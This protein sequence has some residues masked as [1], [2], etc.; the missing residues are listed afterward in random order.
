[1]CRD[2]KQWEGYVFQLNGESLIRK[3]VRTCSEINSMAVRLATGSAWA[4]Y[5]MASTSRRCPSTYRGSE[6]RSRRLRPMLG[7]TGIVK[8]LA[9]RTRILLRQSVL[10]VALRQ[11]RYTVQRPACSFSAF[12]L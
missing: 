12:I 9:M 1:M 7:G 4:R 5:F 6:V 11:L 2:E 3:R 8:T 10:F